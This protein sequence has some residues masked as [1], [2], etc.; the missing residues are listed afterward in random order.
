MIRAVEERIQKMDIPGTTHLSIGQEVAD[1]DIISEYNN[2]FVF[3][4]H[5]SHGQYLALTEDIEGLFK[6]L[7]EH[8]TQHLYKKDQIL[9]NG[10]QGGLTPVAVGMA[11]AFKR[12]G[13]D[14]RVLCFIGD[15]TT[16]QGVLYE[17]LNLASIFDVPITFIMYNN[18]Y[19]MDKTVL[20]N[21]PHVW[22]DGMRKAFSIPV[23]HQHY[24]DVTYGPE[25]HVRDV[26]RL[27]GH[28][29]S[30]TQ[31]YRPEIETTQ[32]WRDEVDP[33]WWYIAHHGDLFSEVTKRVNKQI[34][35]TTD[36]QSTE[37]TNQAG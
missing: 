24:V 37:K 18:G 17:A 2:P 27:C 8:K 9:C 29:V 16:G 33:V 21:N 10:I 32:G 4:N 23:S 3:G 12:K 14:R 19:S 13:I 22:A 7:F 30:D 15:G 1:V 36:K 26:P 11:Y 31:V 28:S 20:H 35:E 34:D 25:L 5:R 6:Q